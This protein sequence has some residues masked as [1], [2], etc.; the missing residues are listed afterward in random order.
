MSARTAT[1]DFQASSRV[2]VDGIDQTRFFARHAQALQV[3]S[4]ILTVV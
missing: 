4:L 3:F 1:F 2:A